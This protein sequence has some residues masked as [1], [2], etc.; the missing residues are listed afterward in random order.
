MAID[1]VIRKSVTARLELWKRLT[2]LEDLLSE[3]MV[4]IVL[5]W[6]PAHQGISFHDTADGLARDS[7]HSIFVGNLYAPNFVTYYDAT[8]IA[9]D[10]AMKSWQRKWDQDISGFYTRWLIPKLEQR[11]SFQ[12]SITLE[13]SI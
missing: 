8:K 9:A 1:I 10:I 7:A 13:L 6:I 3:M 12:I 4:N 11:F 5:V 2:H